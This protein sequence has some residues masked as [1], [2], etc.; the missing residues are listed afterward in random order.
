[1][2]CVSRCL[3]LLQIKRG[4]RKNVKEITVCGIE[5]G[6]IRKSVFIPRE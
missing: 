4:K 2:I 6:P 3:V 1:M 5:L